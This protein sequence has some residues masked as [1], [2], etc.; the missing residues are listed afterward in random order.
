MCNRENLKIK[1]ESAA[2]GFSS[3]QATYMENATVEDAYTKRLYE[4]IWKR[5][6][7]SQIWMQNWNASLLGLI[8]LLIKKNPSPHKVKYSNSLV[9][10]RSIWKTRDEEDIT[11]A[12]QHERHAVAINRITKNCSLKKM[13]VTKRITR[14][15]A[16]MYRSISLLK[17][18]K[19]FESARPSTYAPTI[20]TILKR[21]YVEKRDK[22]GVTKISEY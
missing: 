11:K 4:L 12:G 20:S 13:R 5:I 6:I 3:D 14:L 8:F 15:V 1:T 2:G 16:K 19:N 9:L 18:L 22:E 7:T 21:G 10:L 17:N